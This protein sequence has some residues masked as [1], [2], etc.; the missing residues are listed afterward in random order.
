[1]V[2]VRDPIKFG[3]SCATPTH[4]LFQVKQRS[5][6]PG[7]FPGFWKQRWKERCIPL[8]ACEPSRQTHNQKQGPPTR[9]GS[10]PH[11]GHRLA[12]LPEPQPQSPP[13]SLPRSGSKKEPWDPQ[14]G[15]EVGL[16]ALNQPGS[17]G[18][19]RT[20]FGPRIC[21]F[22]AQSQPLRL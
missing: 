16:E 18:V 8:S 12:F 14:P 20:S 2:R 22:R 19:P 6:L 15:R 4:L 9:P 3:G 17:K 5:H 7:T 11:P 21:P 1:M 10:S 13:K